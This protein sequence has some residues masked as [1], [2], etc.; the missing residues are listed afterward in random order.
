[1]H[2]DTALQRHTGSRWLSPVLHPASLTLWGTTLLPH[3]AAQATDILQTDTS[4]SKTMAGRNV[5]LRRYH[6]ISV[7][8]QQLNIWH[9]VLA[10]LL[11]VLRNSMT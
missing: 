2:S 10:A 7:I 9:F 6:I 8:P 11:G 4:P 5:L 3:R 1:M